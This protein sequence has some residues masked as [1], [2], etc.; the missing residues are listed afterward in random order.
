MAVLY[1]ISFSFSAIV[2]SLEGSPFKEFGN[3]TLFLELVIP[4]LTGSLPVKRAALLGVQTG[5]A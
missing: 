1:C 4:L 5:A 3:K 2:N